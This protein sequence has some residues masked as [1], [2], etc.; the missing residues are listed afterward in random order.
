MEITGNIKSVILFMVE[1]PTN[2]NC[3]SVGYGS[4]TGLF[5]V[6]ALWT[7]AWILWNLIRLLWVYSD[8][9]KIHFLWAIHLWN[10]ALCLSF[11]SKT[12]V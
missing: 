11:V 7:P 1:T 2:S 9:S 12:S 3:F 5:I 10:V 4:V 8:L 6:T